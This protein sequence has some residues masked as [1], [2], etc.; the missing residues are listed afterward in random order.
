[1]AEKHLFSTDD[2][3]KDFLPLTAGEI[4]DQ[5]L[6]F[7]G[8]AE[9]QYIV[10]LIGQEAFD[11]IADAYDSGGGTLTDDEEDLLREIRKPLAAYA[12]MLYIPHGQLLISPS[13]IRIANTDTHKTAFKWQIDQIIDEYFELACNRKEELIKW[14]Y[15]NSA[16]YTTY[17]AS[18]A[19]DENHQFILNYASELDKYHPIR[20]SR[21]TYDSL[22]PIIR[23]VETLYIRQAIS[24]DYY[25]ELITKL[26]SDTLTAHDE[27]ILPD[28][29]AAITKLAIAESIKRNVAR[30]EPG[31]VLTFSRISQSNGGTNQ[32][33]AAGDNDKAAL[34]RTCDTFGKAYIS[35]VRE[36]LN[37]NAGSG[38]FATFYNSEVYDD[39]TDD[40]ETTPTFSNDQDDAKIFFV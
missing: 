23:D 15:T 32:Q 38:T 13:G 5:V 37:T 30:V 31:G 21:A 10:P 1:M 9:R 3:L 17:A 35:K 25:D 8:D 4:L 39:P 34:I 20:R 24:D 6:P 40:D 12:M 27:I 29:K 18:D 7:V 26:R 16:T 28:L 2:E 22:I 11:E 19:F 14:L 36:Y 33:L